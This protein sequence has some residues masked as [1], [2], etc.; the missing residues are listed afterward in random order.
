MALPG[1]LMAMALPTQVTTCSPGRPE[2]INAE[3][4]PVPDQA[5]IDTAGRVPEQ[6]AE[7]DTVPVRATTK[8]DEAEP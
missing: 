3:P 8:T 2:A 5:R 7:A 4:E 1:G 6:V